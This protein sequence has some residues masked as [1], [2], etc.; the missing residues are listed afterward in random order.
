MTWLS[1][2][3]A[4]TPSSSAALVITMPIN[5]PNVS[6]HRCRLHPLIF[7]PLPYPRSGPPVLVILTDWLSIEAAPGGLAPRFHPGLFAHCLDQLRPCLVV[8][9]LGK[10]VIDC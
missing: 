7:L 1:S 3:G 5:R 10:G 2:G 6:T 4:A 8:A 9:P